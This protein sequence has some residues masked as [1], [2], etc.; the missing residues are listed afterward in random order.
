MASGLWILCASHSFAVYVLQDD[1][2][3]CSGQVSGYQSSLIQGHVSFALSAGI[4]VLLPFTT[5]LLARSGLETQLHNESHGLTSPPVDGRCWFLI[6]F[7]FLVLLVV[8]GVVVLRLV[9]LL[10]NIII[11]CCCSSISSS[12]SGRSRSSSRSGS[13]RRRRSSRSTKSRGK[14]QVNSVRENLNSVRE[15]LLRISLM[16]NC[17]YFCSRGALTPSSRYK[18]IG[19]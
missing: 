3:D 11:S 8:A 16:I 1:V 13:S 7:L 9:L 12:S 18:W 4:A 17:H 19:A 2:V 6:W 10:L 14:W 5:F 15:S